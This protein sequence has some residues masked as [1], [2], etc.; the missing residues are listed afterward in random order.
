MTIGCLDSST[1]VKSLY[2][3][4]I[5]PTLAAPEP[6]LLVC[7][8]YKCHDLE[9]SAVCNLGVVFNYNATEPIRIHLTEQGYR[10][11]IIVDD[12]HIR[13]TG[14]LQ[15]PLWA[16]GKPNLSTGSL[17]TGSAISSLQ[18]TTVDR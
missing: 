15:A 1:N 13:V 3:V 4:E 14:L 10:P 11:S 5:C 6:T 12:I 2:L 18:T 7:L 16:T 8:P 9:G 17:R